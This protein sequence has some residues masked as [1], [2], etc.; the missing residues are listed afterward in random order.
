M[1]RASF[2]AEAAFVIPICVFIIIVLVYTVFVMHDRAC[3]YIEDLRKRAVKRPKP[4]IK[5]TCGN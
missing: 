5:K 4:A 1:K 3:I 2:T